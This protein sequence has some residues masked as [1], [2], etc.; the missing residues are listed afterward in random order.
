MKKKK[1][2]I[3]EFKEFALKGNVIDLTVGIIV[4]GAFQAIVNSLVKDVFTP[5]I[6]L[7]GGNL[8]FTNMFVRIG[9]LP[10]KFDAS[11]LG[12]IS[13]VRGDLGVAVFAYGSFITAVINFL[14]MAL[15]IFMIVKGIN[16]LKNISLP[17]QK[18]AVA[19]EVVVITQKTC[20][21]CISVIPIEATRCPHCTSELLSDSE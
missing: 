6:G 1:K 7:L 13:Y 14:M 2:I 8:D 10:E 15:I 12:S 9:H 21:Y 3:G 5:L 18:A 20:P 16:K 19:E 11:K 4:G 17:G